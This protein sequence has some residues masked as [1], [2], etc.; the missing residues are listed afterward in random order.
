VKYIPGQVSFVDGR[1]SVCERVADVRIGLKRQL[2]DAGGVRQCAARQM[3]LINVENVRLRDSSAV[4]VSN[5]PLA[6]EG[7]T[8]HC[9]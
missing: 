3:T 9:W 4:V 6:S 7:V 1:Q 5:L 2:V 8:V